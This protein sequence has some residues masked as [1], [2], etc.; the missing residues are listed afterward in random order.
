MSPCSL[1]IML[2][3]IFEVTVETDKWVCENVSWKHQLLWNICQFSYLAIVFWYCCF[4]YAGKW[5]LVKSIVGTKFR[6]RHVC[7]HSQAGN[8]LYQP[9]V[10][11]LLS[12][13]IHFQN[14]NEIALLFFGMLQY[15]FTKTETGDKIKYCRLRN[16]T[17]IQQENVY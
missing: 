17:E 16:N 4:S 3:R 8:R 2:Y 7:L 11:H 10:R 9:V 14:Y 12:I 1:W 13:L 15:L 6:R 5:E